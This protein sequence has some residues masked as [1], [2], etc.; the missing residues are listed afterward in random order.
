[1]CEVWS[2]SACKC[3]LC[4]VCV[5][6]CGGSSAL[7]HL[8]QPGNGRHEVLLQGLE[9]AVVQRGRDARD[10][11]PLDFRL[12]PAHINNT[13]TKSTCN[14]LSTL[15]RACAW[16]TN[17]SQQRTSTGPPGRATAWSTT[18]GMNTDGSTLLGA[19][20]VCPA[21]SATSINLNYI[22]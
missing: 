3:M 13:A 15:S 6:V 18:A 21:S 11:V 14:S 4:V 20:T 9:E 1:M 16:A 17:P 7:P 22:H 2:L 10:T 5:C 12:R 19:S 8:K